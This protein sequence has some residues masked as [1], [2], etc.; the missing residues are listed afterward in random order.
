MEPLYEGK[1]F[2]FWYSKSHTVVLIFDSGYCQCSCNWKQSPS[3]LVTSLLAVALQSF[4]LPNGILGLYNL[5]MFY[6][7]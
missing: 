2:V 3:E 6:R 5:Q 1:F 7:S 4:V